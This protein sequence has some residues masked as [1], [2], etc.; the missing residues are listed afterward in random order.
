MQFGRNLEWEF[1]LSR[2][3]TGPSLQASSLRPDP[4]SSYGLSSLDFQ[5][6][7]QHLSFCVRCVFQNIL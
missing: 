3:L 1:G 2:E 4:P 7:C 6:G 5:P